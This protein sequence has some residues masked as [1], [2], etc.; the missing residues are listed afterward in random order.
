MY[1]NR[2]TGLLRNSLCDHDLTP[3]ATT[4]RETRSGS[5]DRDGG[6][7]DGVKGVASRVWSTVDD[8]QRQASQ[9]R[10]SNGKKR[11]RR[12][13]VTRSGDTSTTFIRRTT[14]TLHSRLDSDTGGRQYVSSSGS[15][16]RPSHS[17]SIFNV[18]VATAV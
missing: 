11:P 3:T 10:N 18:A 15:E 6:W 17:H 13:T 9:R 14:S 16:T 12:D 8:V 7:T 5:R 1:V 2:E 4:V